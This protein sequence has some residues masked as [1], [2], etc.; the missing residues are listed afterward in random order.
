MKRE[1]RVGLCR[2][3]LVGRGS[4]PPPATGRT[5]AAP[6]ATA[7]PTR[8]ASSDLVARRART[9]L[10]QADLTGP[11]DAHR[12][13]TAASARAAAAGAGPTR[14]ELVA[15]FDADTGKKLWERRFPRLQHHRALHAAWAGPR[16]AGDPETGYVYAQNVDGQLVVPR[17]R[18]QD[19]L[20]A[21]AG[22]GVRPRLRLR[23]PHARSRWWTRTAWSWA[24]WAR[25]GATS[26]RRA[27]ATWPSTRRRA[28]CAGSR[29]PRRARSTT[30]TT[31]RARRWR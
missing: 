3:V 24:S 17:P 4:A 2:L 9:S 10:W 23:R 27:S 13:S 16:S 28:P 8:R 1:L 31:R 11:R 7:S 25:A 5:G 19:G 18:G 12:A 26:G 15:C 22:R 29:R 30:P 14:H 21:P 6:T 20:A